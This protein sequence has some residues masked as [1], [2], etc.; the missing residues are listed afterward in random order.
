MKKNSINSHAATGTAMIAVLALAPTLA[1]A[2]AVTNFS[3]LVG[4][5]YGMLASLVPII[6]S[7]TVIVFL[8][9]IFQLVQ[10]NNEDS[11]KD[12]IRI[13]TFGVVALFVMVSVWGL[14]AILSNTFFSGT[15]LIPQLR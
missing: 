8:W 12:A 3:G 15:P 11:R 1:Y 6:I 4:K 7:L 10:S 5:I 13:I 9:G 2:Q 14:V